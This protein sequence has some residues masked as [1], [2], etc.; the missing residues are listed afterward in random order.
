MSTP[1]C[2][3]PGETPA[4]APAHAV[5]E[6]LDQLNERV[7]AAHRKLFGEDM[8]P[9]DYPE[10]RYAFDYALMP[11]GRWA[12]MDTEE[13]D[14]YRG[15]WTCPAD[16]RTITYIEGDVTDMRFASDAEYLADLE[17]H[18]RFYVQNG[19][20]KGIDAPNDAVEN[21]L[22]AVGADHMLYS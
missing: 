6:T 8:S 2:S 9:D 18:Y 17:T 20:W 10:D 15:M 5:R 13:D 12:Q 3:Q 11:T 16:R 7:A 22:R 19:T 14:W 21:A 4:G 1:A